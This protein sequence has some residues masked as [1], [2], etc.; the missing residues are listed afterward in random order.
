MEE[1]TGRAATPYAVVAA[2]VRDLLDHAP[3]V[4]VLEDVHWADDATLDV[5]RML[6]RRYERLPVLV[7][8]SHR[9]VELD[10][11][12]PLRRAL[13][14]VRSTESMRRLWLAP[15]SFDS[16]RAIAERHGVDA[17]GVYAKTGGNP[18]FVAEAVRGDDE[19]PATVRDA[20]LGRAAHLGP[21][22]WSLLE[23]VAISVVPAELAFVDAVAPGSL[24][25]ADQCVAAGLLEVSDG[26]VR[27]RHE[28]ARLAV[29]DSI[30]PIR[31]VVLH[32]AALAA[33][34][35][36]ESA[37]ARLA[38]LAQHAEAAGD[39][40]L[41]LRHA[42]AAASHAAAHGAH[43]AA[44]AEYARALRFADRLP[45]D[46]YAE[47]CLRRSS[48]CYVSTLD[49]EAEQAI[50]QA[51]GAYRELG[52]RLNE[53]AA[54][55]RLA[56]L[57]RNVG[58]APDARLV[59]E[60]SISIL[61]QLPPSI[62]LA[63]AYAAA[64]GVA[65]L[66]ENAGE[67]TQWAERAEA[68]A[69]ATGS[70][71]LAES[72]TVVAAAAMA[73]RGVSESTATLERALKSALERGDDDQVGRTQTL[74]GMAAYRERSLARM[75]EH[76]SAG[77]P[78][79][80]ERD[81]AVWSRNL[82][83][84]RSW[85][86]LERGDWDEAARTVSRVI[87]LG[88]TLSTVQAKIVLALLRARRGDPD[89]WTPLDEA[90]AVAEPNEQLWWMGQVAAARAEAAW[91]AGKTGEV[92]PVTDDAFQEAQKVGSPWMIG[93]L[94]LWRRRGGIVEKFQG[95]AAGPSRSS[96]Q[97]NGPRPPRR[98]V[99]AGRRTR[100]RSPSPA[101]TTRRPSAARSTSCS[102][103]V[104]TPPPQSSPA[105]CAAEE[106]GGYRAVRAPPPGRTQ[107]G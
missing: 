55:S 86:E 73:I 105:S 46:A 88:C 44:A 34:E 42:P 53:G 38:R 103:W 78:F 17:E 22:A 31:G 62:E 52:D 10:A 36:D 61:E 91:L 23:A 26:L 1:T 69:R 82:L 80:E 54:L 4:L 40:E 84:M 33:L 45:R 90:A 30:G 11:R 24:A 104:R 39:V 64:A 3:T 85:I 81:L 67:T 72:A 95:P 51:I 20:V 106:R 71:T 27:F 70:A 65:L 57:L 19:V 96:W 60:L 49:D 5:L 32:R 9:E 76:V 56:L 12:H 50:S 83:A 13:G 63:G 25:G 18:F 107:S 48:Q 101:P 99:R 93:E 79:C 94:A 6:S 15:L 68:M 35:E 89:P 98:G 43:H 58:R 16:V 74:L 28:L 97:A 92:A 8:V 100:P 7:V 47:L 21:R 59:V 14:E 41:V 77:L 102:G 37:N 87:S 2:L 66:G 29:V 75:V